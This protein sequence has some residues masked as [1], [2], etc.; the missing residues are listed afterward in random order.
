MARRWGAAVSPP[1][2][3]RSRRRQG[4][5]SFD[6]NSFFNTLSTHQ[7]TP[8]IPSGQQKHTATFPVQAGPPRGRETDKRGV[9][10]RD[11]VRFGVH[12]RHTG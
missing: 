11:W 1:D 8:S 6:H 12:A 9:S 3:G 10:C 4:P 7:N 2:S 5:T